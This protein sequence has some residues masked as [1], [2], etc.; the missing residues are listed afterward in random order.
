M[1]NASGVSGPFNPAIGLGTKQ[2]NLIIGVAPGSVATVVG[3]DD[4]QQAALG[5]F[6]GVQSETTT[7]YSQAQGDTPRDFDPSFLA[8]VVGATNNV[9]D[10]EYERASSNQ[11]RFGTPSPVA[12]SYTVV[13]GPNAA[14]ATG[15]PITVTVLD[16]FGAPVTGVA[17]TVTRTGGTAT[18]GAVSAAGNTN[19]SGVATSTA[20]AS[21]AGTVTGTVAVAGIS[22]TKPFAVTL[23]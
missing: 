20:T 2:D 19:G 12:T 17:V 8:D 14:F 18:G 5:N 21:A 16:Q 10:F 9:T 15:T 3:A 22:G 6:I 23:T 1:A 4:W 7:A 11:Y 13:N